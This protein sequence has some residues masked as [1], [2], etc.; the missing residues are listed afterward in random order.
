MELHAY[1]YIAYRV[2]AHNSDPDLG[3]K[4]NS[5][6]YYILYMQMIEIHSYNLYNHSHHTCQTPLSMSAIMLSRCYPPSLSEGKPLHE[7]YTSCIFEDIFWGKG[8]L[9]CQCCPCSAFICQNT[10]SYLKCLP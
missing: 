8:K 10:F 1:I 5:V 4:L 2:N 9:F 7:R 6:K 3:A